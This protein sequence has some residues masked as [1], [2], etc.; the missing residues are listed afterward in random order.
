LMGRDCSAQ[1]R[2]LLSYWMTNG[3]TC[4][5]CCTTI[6]RAGTSTRL[7]SVPQRMVSAY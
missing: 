2:C 7:A 1:S 5:L 3:I 6:H 4:L